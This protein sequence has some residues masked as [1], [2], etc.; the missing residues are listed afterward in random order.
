M[1]FHRFAWVAAI[2]LVV[3][4][5][6]SATE[7]NCGCGANSNLENQFVYVLFHLACLSRWMLLEIMTSLQG[8]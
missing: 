5:L 6:W 2:L 8:P 3:V 1:P 4:Q 7:A